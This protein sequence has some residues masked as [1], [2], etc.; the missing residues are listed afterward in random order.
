MNINKLL[1]PIDSSEHSTLALQWGISLAQKYGAQLLLLHVIPKAVEEVPTQGSRAYLHAYPSVEGTTLPYF[2]YEEELR[3]V[4]DARSRLSP[5]E[6]VL[7][8][9][10][11]K[12]ETEL[13]DLVRTHLTEPGSATVKVT[14]GKPAEEILQVARDEAVDLIVMGTHGR[15]GLRHALLGSIAETVVRTAPCP[16]FTVKAT[17]RGPS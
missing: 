7:I 17:G 12:T 16:V 10:V 14:V 13:A 8:D 11:E 1:V 6:T 5:P 9:Y 4:L 2:S 3:Q 15:T